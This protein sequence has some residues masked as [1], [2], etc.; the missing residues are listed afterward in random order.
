MKAK[1]YDAGKKWNGCDRYTIYFRFPKKLS[2]KKDLKP[3]HLY[4]ECSGLWIGFN[5][6]YQSTLS[7][8]PDE[9]H[10]YT[11][12]YMSNGTSPRELSFGKKIPIDSLPKVARDW[13]VKKEELWNK[14]CDADTEEAWEEFEAV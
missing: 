4:K 14:A 13:C 6:R 10:I 2:K 9:V 11:A 12:D 8:E 7:K 1:V 5:F 3:N